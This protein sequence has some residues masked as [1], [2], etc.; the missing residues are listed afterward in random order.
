[1]SVLQI[2][3]ISTTFVE[4]TVKVVKKYIRKTDRPYV[5]HATKEDYAKSKL[6]HFRNRYKN[7]PEFRARVLEKNRLR[8]LRIKNE[9]NK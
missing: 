9:K 7:D 1:M 8:R 2:K 6:L 3:N 4:P 5:K